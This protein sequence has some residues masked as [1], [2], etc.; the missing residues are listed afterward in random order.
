MRRLVTPAATKRSTWTRCARRTLEGRNR[1]IEPPKASAALQPNIV[2]AAGLNN[3][4]CCRPSMAMIASMAEPIKAASR[5]RDREARGQAFR[6]M[7]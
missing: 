7:A 1:S 3:T 6:S 5:A 4:T 2:S